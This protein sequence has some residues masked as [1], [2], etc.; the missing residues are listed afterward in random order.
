MTNSMIPQEIEEQLVAMGGRHGP[1]IPGTTDAEEAL[2]TLP[3]IVAQPWDKLRGERYNT[4]EERNRRRLERLQRRSRVNWRAPRC[5]TFSRARG[6]PRAGRRA[7]PVRSDAEPK[8]IRWGAGALSQEQLD[9]LE[10]DTN[11]FL[12]AVED[13]KRDLLEG[14]GFVLEHPGSSIAWMLPEAIELLNL[15][16]VYQVDLHACLF[17]GGDRRKHTKLVTNIP[18]LRTLGRRQ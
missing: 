8:G 5:A 16:G 1:M 14:R 4:Q 13:C 18:E 3:E 11:M 9:G 6:I 10:E 12:Q 7:W 17:E 2:R 15:P